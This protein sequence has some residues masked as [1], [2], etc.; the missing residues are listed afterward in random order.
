MGCTCWWCWNCVNEE[1]K[2]YVIL[3]SSAI[4][5]T[6]QKQSLDHT[7]TV[8]ITNNMMDILYQEGGRVKICA[9]VQRDKVVTGIC[10]WIGDEDVQVKH[11]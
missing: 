1:L 5:S 3:R 6:F 9:F 4:R 2:V 11:K 10:S 7:W 8:D